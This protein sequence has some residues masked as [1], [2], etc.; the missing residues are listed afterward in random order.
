MQLFC[1]DRLSWTISTHISVDTVYG[2]MGASAVMSE[3]SFS[4]NIQR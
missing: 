4:T 1:N 2:K 3:V